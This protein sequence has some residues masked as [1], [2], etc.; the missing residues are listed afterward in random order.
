[1]AESKNAM[2]RL[3]PSIIIAVDQSLMQ[4][5][6]DEMVALRRAVEMVQ[7]VPKSP[8]VSVSDYAKRQGKSRAIRNWVR[9]GKIESRRE[10]TTLMIKTV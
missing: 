6:L 4:S 10:G 1:M 3:T 8:W 2:A 9:D 5:I 7:M